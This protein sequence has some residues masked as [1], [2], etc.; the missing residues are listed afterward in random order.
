MPLAVTPLGLRRNCPPEKHLNFNSEDFSEIFSSLLWYLTTETAFY[1][2]FEHCQFQFPIF[3]ALNACWATEK[4]SKYQIH[5]V[6]V[7]TAPV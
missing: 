1:F 6:Q 4:F 3:R 2:Q 7:I 5:S